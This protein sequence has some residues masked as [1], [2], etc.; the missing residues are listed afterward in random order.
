[1]HAKTKRQHPQFES[2]NEMLAWH[3]EQKRLAEVKNTKS[4]APT[5]SG[6]KVRH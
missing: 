3:R 5:A 2:V 4:F 6:K 1:M